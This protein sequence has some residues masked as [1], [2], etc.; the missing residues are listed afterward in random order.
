MPSPHL[1]FLRPG[2]IC[3]GLLEARHQ[4]R[5]PTT[6][7]PPYWEKPKLPSFYP[8][9]LLL[10]QPALL[11]WAQL[12]LTP[13]RE[14]IIVAWGHKVLGWSGLGS[15]TQILKTNFILAFSPKRNALP[16]VFPILLITSSQTQVL[17]KPWKPSYF[18]FLWL[19]QWM[20]FQSLCLF[21]MSLNN[22][23]FSVPPNRDLVLNIGPLH[24]P[25]LLQQ[26][27]TLCLF[28]F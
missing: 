23:I 12:T 3:C 1:A 21:K 16:L 19:P 13:E 24:F 15:W 6:L 9:P 14:K 28:K 18:L 7:K 20:S 4:V 8:Q 11:S 10:F 25:L 2:H 5:S 26:L 27:L 17:W 22:C